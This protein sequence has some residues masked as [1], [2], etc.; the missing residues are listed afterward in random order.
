MNK[1]KTTFMIKKWEDSVEATM[2]DLCFDN[3]PSLP[4]HTLNI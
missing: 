3:Y 1:G 2:S 4:Q